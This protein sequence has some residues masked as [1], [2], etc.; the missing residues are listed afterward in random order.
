MK[1]EKK[2]KLIVKGLT[3]SQ[4]RSGAFALILSDEGS[5]RIPIMIGTFEAQAIAIALE[6]IQPPRPLTHDLML[7]V[8]NQAEFSLQEVFL[9]KFEDGVFYSEIVIKDSYHEIRIDSRTSDAIALALRTNSP[10]FTTETV[11]K[12]CSIVFDE[13][14]EFVENDKD[15]IPGEISMDNHKDISKLKKQIQKLQKKD[16]ENRMTKAIAEENYELAQIY[17]DELIRRE[18]NG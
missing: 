9:Y 5:R 10:I 11:M 16:I 6:G 12:K 15:L 14:N 2:V 17:N 1:E 4:I 13:S 7:I 18:N 3:N 8:M